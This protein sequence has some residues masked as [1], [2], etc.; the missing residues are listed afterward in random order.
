MIR[1]ATPADAARIAE[2][3]NHYVENTTVT[4][5]ER[6]VSE[7]GMAERIARIA[8]EH[9][10]LV[11]ETGEGIA[12][13]AYAGKWK[14]RS[15]YRFTVESAVYVDRRFHGRGLGTELYGELLGRLRRA[16]FRSVVAVIAMPNEASAALHR[17]FGFQPAGSYREVGFKFG[18][19]LDI[20]SWQLR[21]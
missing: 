2:I 4:F 13:Y 14:E 11:L 1:P 21:L 16:G 8:A 7:A 3:Y 15:A 18:K 20:E 10:W 9:P 6:A 12:G 17:R 5:E 19:W